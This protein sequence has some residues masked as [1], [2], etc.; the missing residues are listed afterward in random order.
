MA[1]FQR[2]FLTCAFAVFAGGCAL[3][4]PVTRTEGA[5]FNKS[6]KEV[7]EKLKSSLSEVQSVEVANRVDAFAT[8]SEKR[9]DNLNVAPKLSDAE[10][11]IITGQ[12]DFLVS[13]SEALKDATTPGTS[14]DKSVSGINSAESKL[15]G[16]TQGLDNKIAGH[17]AITGTNVATFNA[18]AGKVAKIFAAIGEAA[19]TFY[20][21]EKAS[22]I[23]A[24][25]NPDIQ[26][27]CTDLEGVL[28]SDP[29]SKA[30]RTGLAGILFADYEERIASVKYLATTAVLP[31]SPDDP[32][33][34]IRVRERT[35]ILTEYTALLER[36]KTGVAKIRALHK[37]VAEI[38]SAHA[39]LANKD[40]ATFKEKLSNAEELA[41]SLGAGGGDDE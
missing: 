24:V 26:K 16:D 22:K 14:W 12:F 18:D 8:G 34:F 33:Y 6:V 15:M 25:V 36:E 13:Y 21:E 32:N 17:S 9:L 1:H 37:A 4:V 38:A 35:A 5:D 41:R 28:A 20:G 2:T 3:P 40:D 30:P 31:A 29:D 10:V 7:A 27:Y 11:K 39:A 23:A 19:L